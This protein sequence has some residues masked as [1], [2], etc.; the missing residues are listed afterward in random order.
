MKP[1]CLGLLLSL[2]VH[3]GGDPEATRLLTE[4]RA[5]RAV[6]TD[7]PGFTADV[8]I[9]LDGRVSRG[10]VEVKPDGKMVLDL[11]KGDEDRPAAAWARRELGSV[12]GHRLDSGGAT[13][14]PC[15][16]ADDNQ[17]HPLGRA[18]RVLDDEFHSSYRVRDRQIV[19][20]NR[21]MPQAGVR[22]SITVLEN[23]P[24]AEGRFLPVAFVVD[25][26]DLKGGALKSSEAHHQTWQRVGALDLPA[27]ILVV[28]AGAGSQE[29]RSLMLSHHKL[30]H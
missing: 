4:A 28:S 3:A 14:T 9:N 6:W 24:N 26:W 21:T 1:W 20:V 7:F 15:A 18:L 10:Q 19:V 13:P 2:T 11:G 25:S 5:A 22:F 27:T 8:E 30:L 23:R 16:F 29:A 17:H 12:V